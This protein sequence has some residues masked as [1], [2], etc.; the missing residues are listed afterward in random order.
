M[1]RIPGIVESVIKD[2]LF[3]QVGLNFF[4]LSLSA[5]VLLSD[6]ELPYCKKGAMVDLLFKESDTIISL[7]YNATISCRNCFKVCVTDI[8]QTNVMARVTADT[9]SVSLRSLL[10]KSSCTTLGLTTGM[11]VWYLVKSTSCMLTMRE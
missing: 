7:E 6:I 11:N 2:D 5:C 3:A 8:C 10:T 1:N 9:G 4:G